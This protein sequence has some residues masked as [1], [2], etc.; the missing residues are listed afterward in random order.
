M[1]LRLAG[2]W[3]ECSPRDLGDL[4]WCPDPYSASLTGCVGGV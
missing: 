4:S 2:A 3:V 1:F